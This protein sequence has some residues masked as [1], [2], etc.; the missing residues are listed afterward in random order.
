MDGYDIFQHNLL[1]Y[2]QQIGLVLQEPFLFSG[3]LRDNLLFGAPNASDEQL[4]HALETVGLAEQFRQNKI[5]LD[6][7]LTERG[8]NFSTG[9]RQLISF[10]RALLANPRILILDEATAHVDTIT[11]QRI[12]T[13]LDKL[14]EGRTSFII[15]HRLSTIRNSGQILVIGNGQILEQGTHDQLLQLKGEYWQLCNSQLLAVEQ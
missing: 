11:E 7:M 2:R 14:L 15:A 12:Q 6:S 10:A 8:S 1:S 5:T 3:T 4:W 9:Q 13:A